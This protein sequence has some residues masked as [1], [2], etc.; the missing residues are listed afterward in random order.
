MTDQPIR[1]TSPR[2]AP[3]WEALTARRRDRRHDVARVL[4]RRRRARRLLAI[5]GA[6]LYLD[7]SKQRSTPGRWNCCR[8]FADERG[9]RDYFASMFAGE[10]I[11]T[12]EDRA[13]LHVALRMPAG[14]R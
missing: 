9:L 14:R 12:T 1:G 2:T 3:A 6:G 11:N 7:Y 5:E 10:H 4:R 8:S 13:V